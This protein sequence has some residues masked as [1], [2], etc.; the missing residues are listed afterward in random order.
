VKYNSLY[1][2]AKSS[3]LL[4]VLSACDDNTT[5]TATIRNDTNTIQAAVTIDFQAQVNGEDF[6]CGQTYPEVGSPG[7]DYKIDDYRFYIHDVNLIK[8][9]GNKTPLELTQEGVWQYKNIALLDFENG[10]LN[11]TAKMNTQVQGTLPD[12]E[13]LSDYN[14][15]CLTIGLP[16]EENHVDPG[17][18]PSP[19]NA[20]GMLWSWTTGRKFIRIDGLSDPEGLKIPFHL[21]LGSTGCVNAAGT[22]GPPDAP[23]SEPNQPKIC[24]SDFDFSRH[25]IVSDIGKVLSNTN[26]AIDTPDTSI[27]CMSANNDPECITTMPK[28]GLSFMYK[29]TPTTPAV[30][31]P[32]EKQVFLETVAE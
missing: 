14:G 3:L 28:L 25:K 6:V 21:H 19:L 22:G 5:F 20:N 31:Y 9:D 23:C 30:E 16:F 29:Q 12:G 17:T 24:F 8:I 7:N 10:C 26:V 13:V 32:A 11:G 15:I 27:G 4:L 18:A 1:W 2:L